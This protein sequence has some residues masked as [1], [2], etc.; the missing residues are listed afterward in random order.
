[1]KE[2]DFRKIADN[3]RKYRKL[4]NLTQEQMAYALDLDTQYYSQLEQGRRHFT[5]ERVLDCCE[6]LNVKIENIVPT[7]SSSKEDTSDLVKSINDKISTFSRK[8]L[9]LIDKLIGDMKLFF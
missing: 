4:N 2:K 7:P 6:I 9:L 8:E 5:L 3:I 1:M